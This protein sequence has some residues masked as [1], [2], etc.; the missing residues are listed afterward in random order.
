MILEMLAADVRLLLETPTSWGR[1]ASFLL[2]GRSMHICRRGWGRALLLLTCDC[3]RK[4]YRKTKARELVL[5]MLLEE[6]S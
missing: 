6:P 5:L 4:L 2:P 3:R 1:K